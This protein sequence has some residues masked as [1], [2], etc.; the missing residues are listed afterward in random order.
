MWLK[1]FVTMYCHMLWNGAVLPANSQLGPLFDFNSAEISIKLNH[2]GMKDAAQ[3]VLLLISSVSGVVCIGSMYWSCHSDSC[4]SYLF[5]DTNQTLLHFAFEIWGFK[6]SKG[7]I[8]MC[9]LCYTNVA[10]RVL[11]GF[12]WSI[13]DLQLDWWLQ[14]SLLSCSWLK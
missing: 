11:R 3:L 2:N 14:G 4:R 9:I 7:L 12:C 8:K 5:Y 13:R 6:S 1:L 10:T